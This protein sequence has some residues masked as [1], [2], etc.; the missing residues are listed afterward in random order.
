MLIRLPLKWHLQNQT[1]KK[2]EYNGTTVV[3]Y[4]MSLWSLPVLT[5]FHFTKWH[6]DSTF[7]FSLIGVRSQCKI[8]RRQKPGQIFGPCQKVEK[9]VIP[10]VVGDLW[11][12][13]RIC[14]R[15][16]MN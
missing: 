2:L 11:T 15:G 3:S 5:H 13:L 9:A 8:E 10:I 1:L 12:A 14:R 6:F 4:L 16:S 7:F